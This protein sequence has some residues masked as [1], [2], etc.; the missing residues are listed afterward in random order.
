MAGAWAVGRI[1]DVLEKNPSGGIAANKVVVTGCSTNGKDALISGVFEPRVALC[2]PVESGCAGACSWRVSSQYGHGN[3]NTDCQDI[4][5]LE[6]EWLGTVASL[7]RN[8]SVKID[9]LPFD[10][11]ELMALRAPNPMLV[12]D[13]GKEQYKWLCNRG[14]SAAAQGCH[15]IYKALGV[16]ENFGFYQA[17]AGHGHCT[18]WPSEANSALNAFY[19]KF[20]NGKTTTNTNIMNFNSE[21]LE[22]S[23]WFDF[24]TGADKWDTTTVLL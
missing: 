23:K 13:N 19:D 3:S 6:T 24:G 4:T 9:K 7:W 21:S 16:S 1:I 15:W 12:F 2:L 14:A 22:T 18:P 10:Q 20:L 5:H 17:N 11:D 8:G